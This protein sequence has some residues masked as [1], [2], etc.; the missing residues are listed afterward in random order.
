L[1]VCC[2]FGS[3]GLPA[4][5]AGKRWKHVYMVNDYGNK[6]NSDVAAQFCKSHVLVR[7]DIKTTTP[8]RNPDPAWACKWDTAWPPAV[9]RWRTVDSR[10]R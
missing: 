9:S 6:P 2:S 1:L 5:P 3:L 7:F 10:W 8:L 4:P